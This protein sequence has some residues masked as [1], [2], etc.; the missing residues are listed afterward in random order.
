[1]RKVIFQMM[2][3][4]DGYFEGPNKEIDWHVVD[5]EFN[6]YAV[7]LLNSADALLFGRVTYE[8][9]ASYWP[10]PSATTDDPIIADKMNNL[11]KVVFSRTLDKVDWKNSRLVKEN[12]AEEVS[13]LKQQPGKDLAV[14][15]SSNLALTLVQHGLIDEYRIIVN[16]VVLGNGHPLF[17]GLKERL[18]LRLLKTKTFQSGNVMLFYQPNHAAA[19]AERELVIERIFEAPRELVWKTWTE[20]ERVKR[21]WGPKGFTAPVCKVDLRV[22]GVYL[23]CMRSPEGKDYWSTG[24]YR[25]IVPFERIVSTDSFAD[26]KGDVVRATY[27]G[28]SPEFPLEMLLTVTFEEHQG[29]TKLTLRHLGIPPGLE[30]D[31]TQAGWSQSFD[32]LAEMLKS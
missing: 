10:S 28:L 5:A 11:P 22:G 20:P 29:K 9:M 16:P 1:M 2:V 19:P 25:E 15:G 23:Y 17:K 31:S 3:S 26:E 32:K 13:K 21:W 30:L 7:D 4:L 12:I 14:F 24:V 18:N 27:Y 6:E 8:L